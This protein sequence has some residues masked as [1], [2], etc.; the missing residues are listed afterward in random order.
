MYCFHD[1]L[2]GAAA[3]GRWALHD[4]LNRSEQR[5]EQKSS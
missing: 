4:G 5:R 3:S 2:W 1:S